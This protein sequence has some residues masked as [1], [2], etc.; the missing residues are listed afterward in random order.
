MTRK[1]YWG[2]ATLILLLGTAAVYIIMHEIADNRD[3]TKLLEEADNLES[4]LSN[5]RYLTSQLRKN[6]QM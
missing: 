4:G 6:P 2:I 3:L 5:N 1:M